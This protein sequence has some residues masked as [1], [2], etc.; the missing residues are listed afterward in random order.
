MPPVVDKGRCTGCGACVEACPDDLLYM[1]EEGGPILREEW[2]CWDCFS[3]VRACPNRALW[4]RL[5]FPIG[6]YGTSMTCSVKGDKEVWLLKGPGGRREE[7]EVQIRV[8]VKGR[9]ER[10]EG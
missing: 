8:E 7:R 5:P 2:R 3:C 4:M 1:G 10:D 9:D 6:N